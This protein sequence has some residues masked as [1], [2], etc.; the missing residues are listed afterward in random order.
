MADMRRHWLFRCVSAATAAL[1]VS[2]GL[3]PIAQAVQRHDEA[4]ARARNWLPFGS[5]VYVPDLSGVQL[6]PDP[7]RSR[8]RDLPEAFQQVLPNRL[9]VLSA[10]DPKLDPWKLFDRDSSTRV[11]GAF[12]IQAHFSPQKKLGGAALFV[13]TGGAPAGTL[14][15][16]AAKGTPLELTPQAGRA[17]WQRVLAASAQDTSAVVLEW[18]PARGQDSGPSELALWAEEPLSANPS[19]DVA[20]QLFGDGIAGSVDVWAKPRKAAVTRTAPSE[21]TLELH[22][23]P[24]ALSRAFLVYELLGAPHFTNI[25]RELNGTTTPILV[26]APRASL[27]AA[28]PGAAAPLGSGG[29]QVEE[30]APSVLR[31]GNNL[32]KFLPSEQLGTYFVRNVRLVG[33]AADGVE[34]ASFSRPERSKAATTWRS[35]LSFERPIQ[36]HEVAFRLEHTSNARLVFTPKSGSFKHGERQVVELGGLAAG[37]QK[38]PLALSASSELAVDLIGSLEDVTPPISAPHVIGSPWPEPTAREARMA[39][40]YPKHGE[41]AGRTAEVRGFVESS[42]AGTPRLFVDGKAVTAGFARGGSFAAGVSEPASARGKSWVTKLEAVYP[43]GERVSQD[44]SLGPCLDLPAVGENDLREDPGAPLSAV[45]RAHKRQRLVL[46]TATLEIPEGALDQ[47]VR[48][49]MRPL[50]KEQVAAMGPTMTNVM[51]NGQAY[52]FGPHGL[53]FKKP[54]LLSFAYDPSA[55]PDGLGENDIQGLFFNEKSG[56]WEAIGRY[57]QARDGELVT[58]TDHFTD[59]VAAT[60]AQPDAPGPQSYNPTQMKDLQLADPAAGIQLVQPP[61]ANNSGSARLGHGIELPPGRAQLQPEIGIG[62]DSAAGN[63]W[64]G[65]GWDL[66]LSSIRIDTRNGVPR[67]TG[68]EK[69]LLDGAMLVPVAGAE[70]A[71]SANP[72]VY[73]RRVE[74]SFERIERH[75]TNAKN[76]FWVVTAKSGV[77]TTYGRCP[78][79]AAD[80]S[81]MEQGSTFWTK[82]DDPRAAAGDANVF[83]WFIEKREDL[84]GNRMTFRYTRDLW[85]RGDRFVHLYPKHVDYTAHYTGGTLDLA[86]AYRVQFGLLKQQNGSL[87]QRQDV[88]LDGLPGFPTALRYLLGNVDVKLMQGPGGEEIIRRYRLEYRH[89]DAV[90]DAGHMGKTLLESITMLGVGAQNPLYRHSFDY[91]EAEKDAQNRPLLFDAQKTWGSAVRQAD[92][93]TRTEDDTFGGGG[94]VGVGIGPFSLTASAGGFDGNDDVKLSMLDITGDGLVDHFDDRQNSVFGFLDRNPIAVPV[95]SGGFSPLAALVNGPISGD[96]GHSDRSGWSV[97]GNLSLG[98]IFGGSIG[99]TRTN[100]SDDRVIADMDGD[101][102]IDLVGIVDGRIQVRR[103][104]GENRFEATPTEWTTQIAASELVSSRSDRNRVAADQIHPVDPLIKWVAPFSGTVEVNGAI[105]RKEAGGDGVTAQ[106]FLDS[107]LVWQHTFGPDEL[108][109]CQPAPQNG[110]GGGLQVPLFATERLYFKATSPVDPAAVDLGTDTLKDDL[111]VGVEFKYAGLSDLDASER[112]PYGSFTFRY[113]PKDDFRLAGLP[114]VPWVASSKGKLVIEGVIDKDGTSPDD[115]RV[116]ITRNGSE[117]F[118]ANFGAAE[119]KQVSVGDAIDVESGDQLFFNVVSD[120][121]IDPHTVKWQPVVRYTEY[122][123]FDRD[124]NQYV[125]G[126]VQCGQESPSDPRITCKIDNDPDPFV[127][128]PLAVIVQ[129]AQVFYPAYRWQPPL[130]RPS[131]RTPSPTQVTLTSTITKFPTPHDVTVYVQGVNRLYHKQR[132]AAGQIVFGL[133]QTFE[134]DLPADEQLFLSYFSEG[135]VG[136]SFTWSAS[137]DGVPAAPTPRVSDAAPEPMSGGFHRFFYGDWNGNLVFNESSIIAEAPFQGMPFLF[138]SPR[139]QGRA[140][141][142]VPSWVGRG[143]DSYIAAGALK[144]ARLGT[145]SSGTRGATGGLE[146]LRRSENWNA[147]LGVTV[148]AN[149]TGSVGDTTSQLDLIDFNGDRYPDVLTS[150]G[151]LINDA[152]NRQFLTR[153]ALGDVDFPD[154]D[155]EDIRRYE[156]RS[157]GVALSAGRQIIQKTDAKGKTKGFVNTA[158]RLG[159]NYGLTGTASDL[160]DV[161]GDALPDHVF[162]DPNSANMK[163]RLN[164]GYSFS[165]PIDWQ[166]PDWNVSQITELQELITKLPGTDAV[167]TGTMRLDDTASLNVG[168]GVNVGLFGGGAGLTLTTA[169]QTIDFVDVNGDGLPD[170]VLRDPSE[171]DEDGHEWIRVKLNLGD[172]FAPEQKWPMPAWSIQV[173]PG[174]FLPDDQPIKVSGQKALSFKRSRGFSGSF[175]V[176][177][178]VILCVG[179]NFYYQ[180]GSGYSVLQFQDIDGDG[181]PDH[182]LKKHDDRNVYVKVNKLGKT[183]LLKSVTRPLGGSFEL[184]YERKGNLI[185]NSAS[186]RVDMPTSSWVLSKTIIKSSPG[187]TPAKTGDYLVQTHE[188]GDSFYDRAERESYGF[189]RVFTRRGT[190]NSATGEYENGDGSSTEQLFDNQNYYQKGLLLE[191]TDRGPNPKRPDLGVQALYTT[192]KHAYAPVPAAVLSQVGTGSFFP[193]E[194]SNETTRFEGQTNSLTK[195]NR[196]SGKEYDSAGNLTR[197]LDEND[198][199]FT[200]DDVLYTIKY[201]F[202]P[203]AYFFRPEIVRALVPGA[204]VDNPLPEQIL[205]ERRAGYDDRG[206]MTSMTSF[207]RGGKDPASAGGQALYDGTNNPTWTFAYTDALGRDFGNITLVKDPK[208][209]ELRYEFDAITQSHRTK[210]TDGF[211]HTSTSA[212]NL[213]YGVPD[214][215]EDANGHAIRF[216]YDQ[217]GR[218]LRVYGPNDVPPAGSN[219]CAD[220]APIEPTIAHSY[221]I[222]GVE[223]AQAPYPAWASTGHKDVQHALDPIV[224]AT[225]IDGAKRT[226]QTK[227]DLDK[228]NGPGTGVGPG[229]TT[230]GMTVSGLVEFDRLGRVRLDHQPTFSTAP[231]STFVAA[232]AKNP[233]QTDYDVLNRVV[234]VRTANGSETTTEYGIDTFDGKT[235]FKTSVRDAKQNVRLSYADADDSTLAVVEHNRLGD[236][237]GADHCEPG[238]AGCTALVT[239]YSFDALDQLVSVIDAKGNATTSSYDT[240]GRMVELNSPDAGKTEWSFDLG[241]NLAARQTARL[242]AQGATTRISYEYD[243]NRIR[244]VNYPDMPAVEYFYGTA[245]QKGDANGNRAGRI[246]E[247]RSEAGSKSYT[248]DRLGNLATETD[249][250]VNLTEPQKG[251]HAYTMEYSY[252]SFSRMLSVKFPDSGRELVEYKYDRGGRIQSIFG[253]LTQQVPQQPAHTDYLKHLGYD[254]FN[255]KRRMVSGNNIETKYD[256]DPVMRRLTNIFAK[257]RDTF[258]AKQNK[259]AR[260]FQDLHYQYDPVGNITEVRNDAP[261][262]DPP[263]S[264]LGVSTTKYTFAYDDLYQVRRSEGTL[265]ERQQW[266]SR[267]FTVTT[268]DEVGNI[269]HKQ[270]K[271]DRYELSG[272]DFIFNHTEIPHSFT[273]DYTYGSG[274]PH[275]VSKTVEDFPTGTAPRERNFA[276]DENGNPTTVSNHDGNVRSQTWDSEDRLKSVSDNGEK[277]MD[278][279]YDCKGMRSSMKAHDEEHVYPNQFVSDRFSKGGK[280]YITKHIFADGMRVADKLDA[281]FTV[282]SPA[283]FYHADHLG[284]THYVSNNDQDLV[285]HHEYFASGEPWTV[286]IDSKYSFRKFTT[287][288][289]KELDAFTGYYNYGARYYE[290]R[291]GTFLNPDPDLS[292][293]MQG[294]RNGGVHSPRNLGLYTYTWNNPVMFRDPT[295]R[296]GVF[297]GIYDVFTAGVRAATNFLAPAAI[298]AIVGIALAPFTGGLSLGSLVAGGTAGF[299]K[300]LAWS[301]TP[302]LGMAVAGV[303]GLIGLWHGIRLAQADSYKSVPGFF[304]FLLDNTWSLPNTVIGSVFNLF[305]SGASVDDK[306]SEGTGQLYLKGSGKYDTTFGN[307]TIG[308]KVPVHEAVHGW[309]ARLF[310]PFFY[311]IYAYNYV[312]NIVPWWLIPKAFGAYKS[313]PIEG[314]GTYFTR[315]VYPFVIFEIM[316]Y[317]V[318]GSPP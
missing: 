128:I 242:R 195:H 291:L 137:V 13:A 206:R 85:E 275:A 26:A 270:Q 292:G 232:P 94:S 159:A 75:G 175:E 43:S 296:Y 304:A 182:V 127:R 247:E 196:E 200:S 194:L 317:A 281:N 153:D 272:T 262:D 78:R 99:Y 95:A 180:E 58:L 264:I 209:F 303:S 276:Y 255:Q 287:F 246:T 11:H 226:L 243:F 238:A 294:A 22:Q 210:T 108:G 83:E 84:S 280:H 300:G 150:R 268:Y 229:A 110:C 148:V 241:G 102:L 266:Q 237:S 138:V 4:A 184:D 63:G 155:F 93:M 265:Q 2:T 147:T 8:P 68:D 37:W 34:Q 256:Y 245:S 151:V 111:S 114:A 73:Q 29:L 288:N 203:S 30:I 179:A 87:F 222:T 9:E 79:A 142:P 189:G 44:I 282:P 109:D 12:R 15:V 66:G 293:Y 231:P 244:K 273:F 204:D 42:V 312:A 267:H 38:L 311:P 31:R 251:P 274:R 123:R 77:R 6:E 221:G 20:D 258:L 227:K 191:I 100:T 260:T 49:T 297:E 98:G 234:R 118:G 181:R 32:L 214:S 305:L 193:R 40:V 171:A 199:D 140:N 5:G 284:S 166:S 217:F 144:P 107:S 74:G 307:V 92:G 48:I 136:G 186:P 285:Q 170:Q 313:A 80:P 46:G 7:P 28:L 269:T 161:N 163:V 116:N 298:G 233:T 64:L 53:K 188:Y 211:G 90:G 302:G 261:W 1:V 122:C 207:L 315:G 10:E 14:K 249:S 105:R 154:G 72:R 121:Q 149:F 230:S 158:F 318:E 52:R 156:N 88:V 235:L 190:L 257:S 157:V 205:R 299:M 162:K 104:I 39:V 165:Q 115:L 103:G 213:R 131:F 177:I 81:C 59:F 228:D 129:P 201:K 69:Y 308:K 126:T 283:F 173:D 60:I 253:N 168:A 146:E 309:Q 192:R 19:V 143:D 176:N 47:D 145:L 314:F 106:L 290:P 130:V 18:A 216:C 124:R 17:G 174:D 61:Q 86:P 278:A 167:K 289:D 152:P 250:I 125:C 117:I 164:L 27:P 112:Q 16:T 218:I 36:A 178:C 51:P 70:G 67:Y 139:R 21:L 254:E 3:L 141:N 91:F 56:K 252:D 45:A 133:Q 215:T 71:P 197:M 295:G 239:R 248:Y 33:V 82:L 62:Y 185:A 223:P 23:D 132:F 286:E 183:N 263:G 301:L 219:A 25:S 187:A 96:L 236:L 271:D 54:I 57:E 310:G 172:H 224:T 55:I 208:A 316:A 41:C 240:V 89:A 198:L 160:I 306:T 50:T 135:D 212:L 35:R 259:P 113:S 225:F 279:V 24:R 76:Y 120:S 169:R 202:D 119:L 277:N 134:L 101:G 220:T 97:E 65:L